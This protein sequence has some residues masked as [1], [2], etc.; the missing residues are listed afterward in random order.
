MNNN[1]YIIKIIKYF[2]LLKVKFKYLFLELTM[3]KVIINKINDFYF[4]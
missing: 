4:K 1:K 2:K 3:R